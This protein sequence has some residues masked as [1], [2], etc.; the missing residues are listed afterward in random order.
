[1]PTMPPTGSSPPRIFTKTHTVSIKRTLSLFSL[2]LVS[3]RG[4]GGRPLCLMCLQ[5]GCRGSRLLQWR[6]C[7]RR[8][9]TTQVGGCPARDPSHNFHCTMQRVL[10]VLWVVCMCRM[11]SVACANGLTVVQ[12]ASMLSFFPQGILAKLALYGECIMLVDQNR[13]RDFL[14]NTL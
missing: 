11:M 4:R 7:A 12:P 6:C 9:G 5:V 2:C 8:S 14:T 1:M 13:V 10:W 3:V